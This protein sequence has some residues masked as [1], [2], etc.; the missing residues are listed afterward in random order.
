V[1]AAYLPGKALKS[2]PVSM[3]NKPRKVG[4]TIRVNMHAGKIVEAT[5]KAII[6]STEGVKYQ[7]DFGNDQTALV[8]EWQ[9]VNNSRRH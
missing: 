7:V 1:D 6:N 9:V 2:K 4:D 8:H 5:I 3:M